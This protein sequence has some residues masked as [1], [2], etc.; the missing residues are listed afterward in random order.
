MPGLNLFPG[1]ITHPIE[2]LNVVSWSIIMFVLLLS[3]VKKATFT[4]DNG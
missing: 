2:E 4:V 1:E 3:L